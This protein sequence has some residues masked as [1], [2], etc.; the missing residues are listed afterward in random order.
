MAR[1]IVGCARGADQP[2]GATVAYLTASG[3]QTAGHEVVLWLTGDGVRL[4]TTGGLDGVQSPD[5]PAVS[6]LHD[7]FVAAGGRILV[8]PVCAKPR[9]IGEADLVA[10]AALQ[11]VAALMQFA[12]DAAMTFSY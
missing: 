10:G 4:A 5:G 7:Q 1:V 11:G 6:G 9:G 8:C 2:D 3:A 12:G